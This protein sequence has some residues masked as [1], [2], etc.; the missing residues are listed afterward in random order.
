MNKSISLLLLV[1]GI[2]FL[3]YGISAADSISSSFSRFF[4]GAPTDKTVWFLIGGG[5]STIIGAAGALRD[6]KSN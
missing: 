1:G 3:I 5:F 2:V 6:S 4:T